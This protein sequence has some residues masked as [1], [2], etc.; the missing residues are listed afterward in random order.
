M[1]RENWRTRLVVILILLLSALLLI[2]AATADA[3]MGPKP[4]IEVRVVNPPKE[5]Y[6]LDLLST[7]ENSY[8]NLDEIQHYDR[9]K[10]ELLEDYEENGW[11]PALVRGTR[12]PMWGDL[13]GVRTD[14][15]MEHRFGYMGVPDDFKLIIITPE[16]QI[17]VSEEI[18][19]DA[20]KTVITYDYLTNSV[21]IEGAFMAYLKQFLATCS[22]TLL[23][24][25]V[26]LLLFGFSIKANRK[27]FLSVNILTQLALTATIG[28]LFVK[29]GILVAFLLFVPAELLI[30]I[31][32]S[33]LFTLL[34]KEHKKLRRFLYAITA[35]IVSAA[36]GLII[37]ALT[38]AL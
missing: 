1:R 31:V 14:Y 2:P 21:H 10:L 8:K 37:M 22:S 38:Y 23:I 25:G 16:N 27:V 7:G 11:K 5:E 12:A 4:E 34:L 24:E 36:V 35:N 26:L 33:I 15:G 20:L 9:V 28:I 17:V 18:H 3:D 30:L 29:E 19:R 13:I 32:E 6:Y